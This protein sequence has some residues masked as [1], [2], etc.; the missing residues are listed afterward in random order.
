M[1]PLVP[2]V[3]HINGLV[4]RDPSGRICRIVLNPA[5]CYARRLL[6]ALSALVATE[7]VAVKYNHESLA[8]FVQACASLRK[9]K[10]PSWLYICVLAFPDETF[11]NG[12]RL[13]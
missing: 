10:E 5:H 4:E 12:Y 7:P 11:V 13:R 1:Q 9:A 2:G 8:A 3:F 6:V